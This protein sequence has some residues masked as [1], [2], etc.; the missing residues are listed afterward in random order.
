MKTRGFFVM[1]L[2]VVFLIVYATALLLQERF[3]YTG[4]EPFHLH[5][6][7]AAMVLNCVLHFAG[8]A[9]VERSMTREQTLDETLQNDT[10][11]VEEHALPGI[12]QHF[13]Y[14]LAFLANLG[15]LTY[16]LMA[17]SDQRSVSTQIWLQHWFPL[18][19]VVAAGLPAFITG[20]YH[21]YRVMLSQDN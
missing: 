11:A 6:L 10:P 20:A 3:Q 2:S 14:P 7:A 4:T 18:L 9:V 12:F 15:A 1:V 19:F 13:L 21:H 8:W 17:L 16:L 5:P